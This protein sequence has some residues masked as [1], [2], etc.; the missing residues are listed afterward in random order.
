MD[1]CAPYR[2]AV[3]ASDLNEVNLGD[4]ALVDVDFEPVVQCAHLDGVR[5]GHLSATTAPR[6]AQIRAVPCPDR[7]AP[8]ISGIEVRFA[9]ARNHA[10]FPLDVLREPVARALETLGEQGVLSAGE[11]FN[12]RICAFDAAAATA[13][14]ADFDLEAAPAALSIPEAALPDD[15]ESR[16]P[17]GVAED[18]DVV[19]AQS[20]LDEAMDL[21][22]AA[23]ETEV[24]GLLLG[25]LCRNRE[26]EDLFVDI[27]ALIKAPE[28]NATA[29]SLRFGPRTFAAVEQILNLRDRDEM[30]LGWFH[31][32]PNWCAGCP[33]S[34]RRHCALAS[35][36]FSQADRD[37]HRS[38]FPQAFSQALLI[39]DL[40]TNQPSIDLYAWRMG[41]IQARGYQVTKQTILPLTPIRG[42]QAR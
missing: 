6:P 27:S 12:Y 15:R 13:T 4:C 30:M 38:L 34:R 28:T 3:E 10:A 1:I 32:H 22:R 33:P 40:G 16:G 35:P 42:D 29:S 7:G 24:G 36:F 2:F 37:V 21:A 18:L 23:G 11:Q 19:I 5:R 31:S 8:Y 39:S 9:G 25:R 20:V 41:S 17:R 26:T 14:V